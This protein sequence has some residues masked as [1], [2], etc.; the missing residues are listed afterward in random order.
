MAKWWGV[1]L[2]LKAPTY[3]TVG[4]KSFWGVNGISNSNLGVFTTGL[5]AIYGLNKWI[6]PNYGNWYVKGGFQWYD[7][8]NNGLVLSENQSVGCAINLAQSCNTSRSVWV[9]FVGLG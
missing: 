8:I 4:E 1:P 7:L 9:G 2:T 3:L 6:A 5:T